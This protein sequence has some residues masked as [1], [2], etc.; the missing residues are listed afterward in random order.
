MEREP[1][2][3]SSTREEILRR[4]G[5]YMGIGSTFLAAIASCLFAGWWLDRWLGTQPWLT[6]LGAFVGIATG[7]Y[8]FY[9]IVT[10]RPGGEN[11]SSSEGGGRGD[12]S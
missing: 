1:G 2:R 12:L 5:P 8:M 4:A 10:A 6:L 3:N 7:F 11:G 9:R